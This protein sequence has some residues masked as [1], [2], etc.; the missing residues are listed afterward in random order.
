MS[1]TAPGIGSLLACAAAAAA[2]A[3]ARVS[4]PWSQPRLTI[5][6]GRNSV[7]ARLAACRFDSN[8]LD[9]G[10]SLNVYLGGLRGAESGAVRA[11]NSERAEK[12]EKMPNRS[13]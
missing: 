9:I 3:G 11:H 7:A 6:T 2:R 10:A 5:S 1:S 13:R 12:P 8:S 4:L